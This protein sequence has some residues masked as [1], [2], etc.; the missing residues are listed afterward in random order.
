MPVQ[1][2]CEFLEKSP[3]KKHVC[4]GKRED[5]EEEFWIFEHSVHYSTKNIKCQSVRIPL[6]NY[7][8]PRVFERPFEIIMEK[9]E[10][11][12]WSPFRRYSK[13][14]RNFGIFMS[15]NPPTSFPI[16]TLRT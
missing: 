7:P 4:G 13:N 16:I 6:C 8:S 9:R 3:L 5:Q 15:R 14:V 2:H 12:G 1:G 11:S 10:K